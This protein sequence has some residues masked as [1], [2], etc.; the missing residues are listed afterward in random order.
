[1]TAYLLVKYIHILSATV[2]FGTGLGTAFFFWRAHQTGDARVIAVVAHHVVLADWWFTT[3][4]IIVQ[5]ASGV[6]MLSLSG[7]AAAPPWLFLSYVLYG[8]A[9][10]CWLPVVWLQWRMRELARQAAAQNQALS[11]TYRRYFRIW[12]V[13]GWPAFISVL[14]IFGLMI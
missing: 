2:L 5:P 4:A 14:F 10:A 11:E 9:G 6:L 3:P 7:Y 13:L 12:F 8:V 1:M